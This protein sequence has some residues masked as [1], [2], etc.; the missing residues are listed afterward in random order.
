MTIVVG[1]CLEQGFLP[2][3]WCLLNMQV[4][5]YIKSQVVVI[6]G[7]KEDDVIAKGDRGGF[8]G[9]GNAEVACMW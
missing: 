8:W 4:G 9:A 1:R 3:L 7:G 5:N 6:L 2:A